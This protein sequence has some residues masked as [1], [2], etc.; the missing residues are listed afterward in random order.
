MMMTNSLPGYTL[1][2]L[3]KVFSREEL[4][5]SKLGDL[6]PR[7]ELARYYVD[8]IEPQFLDT[9]KSLRGI[10][11]S[12]IHRFTRLTSVEKCT[13]LLL[14]LFSYNIILQLSSP[15]ILPVI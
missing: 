9:T 14:L 7:L 8:E 10:E 15:I 5:A 2:S 13:F 11:K 12:R 3:P 1:F 4:E 6:L